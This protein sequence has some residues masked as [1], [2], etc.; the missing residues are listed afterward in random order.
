MVNITIKSIEEG[1]V[2]N[3]RDYANKRMDGLSKFISSHGNSAKINVEIEKTTNHHKSGDVFRAEVVI[4]GIGTEVRAASEK[5]DVYASI[6]DVKEELERQLVE[7]K[8]RKVTLFRRGARSVKKMLKG[9]SS[10][11]PFTSKN[12]K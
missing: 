6:D 5:D 4:S 11:N 9:L 7:I 12:K 1:L 10:R 8:D 3:V 2:S